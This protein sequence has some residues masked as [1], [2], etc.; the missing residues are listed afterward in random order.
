MSEDIETQEPLQGKV[1]MVLNER[2]LI[3]N[4]GAEAGVKQNMKFK[5]LSHSPMEIFDPETGELLGLLD[6]EKVRVT[7]SK[8]EPRYS[9]CKTYR[10]RTVGVLPSIAAFMA[11][12]QSVPETLRT[13]DSTLPPPLPEEESYVK[14]GDRVVQILDPEG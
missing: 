5:I 6:R 11:P 13:T 7:V 2:E 1:V 8:L 10:L 4:I 9:I 3:I 14:K 12:V